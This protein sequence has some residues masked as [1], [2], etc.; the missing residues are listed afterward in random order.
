[1]RLCDMQ[2]CQAHA[3]GKC[4]FRYCLT[5]GCNKCFCSDHRGSGT[6]AGRMES[7]TCHECQPR[8]SASF[9][10]NILLSIFIP[11]GVVG[12]YLIVLF[13][14]IAAKSGGEEQVDK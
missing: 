14:L 12:I 10:K 5:K 9:C 7:S 6:C 13:S 3:V 1:M 2:G 4:D 8:L 11:L